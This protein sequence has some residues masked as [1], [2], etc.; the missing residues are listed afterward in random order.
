MPW[1]T[2]ATLATNIIKSMTYP[3]VILL[4][5]PFF[6]L[7][8]FLLSRSFVHVEVDQ[9]VAKRRKRLRK[10]LLVTRTA[11]LL[12]ILIAIA[13]PFSER[14]ITEEGD[15]YLKILLDNST[16]FSMFDQTAPAKLIKE[17]EKR[18]RVEVKTVGDATSS[19]LGDS[20]LSSLQNNANILL[21]SDGQNNQGVDLG[22][23]AL[24]ATR[25]NASISTIRLEPA[26]G[27]IGVT[28]KGPSKTLEE[29][30][31]RFIVQLKRTGDQG[32]AKITVKVD[33]RVILEKTTT[34]EHIPFNYS[35]TGGYHRVAAQVEATKDHFAENNAFYRTVKVVKKPKILYY[36]KEPSPLNTLLSQVYDVTTTA[37]LPDDL[38]SYHAVVINDATVKDL[39]DKNIEAITDFST[40][41]NGVLFV[42]G[43]NSF[44]RGAYKD[45]RLETVLPVYVAE[46]G[47]KEGDINVVIVVDISGSTGEKVP[48]PNGGSMVVDVEKAQAISLYN[49]MKAENK[50]AVVAFNSQAYLIEPASYVYEKVG[51]IDR[52]SKLVHSGGTLISS[53]LIE[54]MEILKPLEGSKNII[55]IS[56]GQTQLSETAFSAAKLADK[57]GIKIYT[58]GVGPRTN[59][60]VMLK[61]SQIANG[62]Y[63]K[64]D[65]SSKLKILFGPTEESKKNRFGLA[66]L[67]E[68]HFI[69]ED[70]PPVSGTIT[71]VNIVVPKSTASMLVSTDVGDPVLTVWRFGLG[72]VGALTTDDGRRFAGELL[73]GDNSFLLLRTLNWLVGDPDRKSQQFID[74]EDTRLGE[75]AK[76]TVKSPTPP[77]A[78]G[79]AF[80]KQ[81]DD[82]Y[83]AT[84]L[85]TQTGFQSVVDAIFA[86]NYPVEFENLGIDKKFYDLI[87]V[88]GGSVFDPG[89]ADKIA[90]TVRTRS[91][92]IIVKK[93]PIRAPF[94][95]AAITLFLFEIAVRQIVRN[96]RKEEEEQPE[97]GSS[98][99]STSSISKK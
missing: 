26:I 1:Q 22:D 15:P 27:D 37:T 35:F 11:I 45:S 4:I 62:I 64:A 49:T 88:T 39:S 69:T 9:G 72:K 6:I 95:I 55:L 57:L 86:V 51:V 68:N 12:L 65:Q 3:W 73:S 47:K 58:V 56:D 99:S 53:G 18:I 31:N 76:L 17:L 16:S 13:T 98:T 19:P 97:I 84:I 52:L 44:E 67:N 54:A 14:E 8:A 5:I 50:V 43:E 7:V 90:D 61:L 29:V 79:V 92:R 74:I 87:T 28:I 77:S 32:P 20:V 85:P 83:T 63:F 2:L 41:G 21:V 24:Y 46:P 10:L 60:F 82:I 91:K 89:D 34:E 23:V 81:E 66:T 71:G 75:T 59:E 80:Y 96:K 38:S 93:V 78:P 30:Q 36:T 40:E 94:I 70:S 48:G 42:G 33:D 25:L